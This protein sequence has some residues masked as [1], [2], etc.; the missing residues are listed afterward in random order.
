[1]KGSLSPE[2]V[3][4]PVSVVAILVGLLLRVCVQ[5]R[6]CCPSLPHVLVVSYLVGG[7]L[8]GQGL[9]EELAL[10]REVQADFPFHSSYI[11]H[12]H[13]HIPADRV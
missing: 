1:M 7:H 2:S 4:F 5:T 3:L 9:L 6:Q 10:E 8:S 12:A 13:L 11:L